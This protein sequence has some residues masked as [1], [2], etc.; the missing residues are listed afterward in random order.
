MGVANSAESKDQVEEVFKLINIDMSGSMTVSEL[1]AL[2]PAEMKSMVEGLQKDGKVNLDEFKEAMAKHDVSKENL[3]VISAKLRIAG[4]KAILP[5]PQVDLARKLADNGQSHLFKPWDEE[6]AKQGK[7]KALMNALS[8]CDAKYPGGL[9]KYI[10]KAKVLLE[11][12][13]AGTN[14]FAGY[15]PEVPHGENLNYGD[16]TFLEFEALGAKE[17][18]A[19]GYVLVAGGLGERLGYGGIKVALPVEITTMTCYLNFYIQNILAFQD[20][21]NAEGAQVKLP[22]AIMTSGDTHDKTVELL[23]KNNYFGM[24][25]KQIVLMKQDKVPALS[26]NNAA[27]EIDKS[28]PFSLV[29]KPHGHGDV[30]LLMYQ[31]GLAKTWSDLGVEWICFF[32]D[33]NGL[34]FNALPACIGVS[35]KLDLE[36]N[37]LT[38]PRKPGEAVG[39]ICKLVP[40]EDGK[41][42]DLKDLTINVEYNQLDA[43]LKSTPVGG[44]AADAKTGLSPYPGNINVLV[45]KAKP[46]AVALEKSHGIVP[47][48]VNPK[49]K[50]STKTVF[51]K[52]TRLEC[53]MQD[54]PRLCDPGSKIG[55]TA[56][57]RWCCFSAVKNNLDDAKDKAAKTGFGESGCTGEADAYK[58]NRKKLRLV[59][60]D[61]D[62]E[63]KTVELAGIPCSSG[64]MVCLHPSFA[65]TL[66]DLKKRFPEPK[67]VSISSRS[68]LVLNGDIT[69]KRL[70]LDGALIVTA[71]PGASVVIDEG[72]VKNE[73]YEFQMLD[74]LKDTSI[75]EKFRIR[76]YTLS[77]KA[78]ADYTCMDKDSQWTIS[79][80]KCVRAEAKK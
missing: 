46:Y 52:P 28:D 39:A 79:G 43:L 73:G 29:T 21:A 6:S 26:D 53:M 5:A 11:S 8:A 13:K 36:V 55:F 48:F 58:I 54:Y 22:L 35:K 51:K 80:G 20:K 1:L 47:E 27:F 59:G 60:V 7:P 64:A 16:K 56:L 68:T 74:D 14:P 42:R 78:A 70:E 37:S 69:I 18:K 62:D 66:E 40:D 61:I 12:S 76:G 67:A 4:C 50:D 24:E 2:V 31:T 75:D 45:F 15:K 65:C 9:V 49:Y 30:H 3:E 72:K 41:K 71:N 57:E 19:S 23:E 63:G 34:V 32:Q 33:T 77:K 38:V 10:E 44:D 17:L 25:K